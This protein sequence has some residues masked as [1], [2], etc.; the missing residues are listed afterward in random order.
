MG[1]TGYH[2]NISPVSAGLACACPRCGRGKL[3]KGYLDVAERCDTCGLDFSKVDSGDGPA[4]FLIFILGF[5]VVPVALWVSMNVE[6]PLWLHA[7][8]WG[9]VVLGLTLGM[10]RPAKALV[11]AQQYRYRRSE[12]EKGE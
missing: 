3:F 5:L 8:V 4:V 2:A 1:L 9:A 12:L 6:W 11:I 10:L 7:L